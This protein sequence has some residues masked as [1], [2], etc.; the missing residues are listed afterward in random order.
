[1]LV[2][3]SRHLLRAKLRRADIDASAARTLRRLCGRST[4]LATIFGVVL[5]WRAAAC[6]AQ[7][8][9]HTPHHGLST[10]RRSL[11]ASGRLDIR[12]IRRLSQSV[13]TQ[14]IQRSK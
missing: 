12:L 9:F 13:I 10:F 8:R 6:I 3:W 2:F 11:R 4:H 14:L 7:C 5:N 1:M